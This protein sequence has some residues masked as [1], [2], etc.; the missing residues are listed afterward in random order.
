MDRDNFARA[1]LVLVHWR[2]HRSVDRRDHARPHGYAG[3]RQGGISRQLEALEGA[4]LACYIRRHVPSASPPLAGGL[5]RACLPSRADKPLVGPDWIYEIKHD[6][7]RLMA[8]LS[9]VG[10]SPC[11]FFG[12]RVLVGQAINFVAGHLRGH[13]SG[14]FANRTDS[15]L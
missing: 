7:Y 9:E 1:A 2:I 6:G 12:G 15:L 4:K 8:D 11:L 14:V 10:L 13:G 5:H 3:G